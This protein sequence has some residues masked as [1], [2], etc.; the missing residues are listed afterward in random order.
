MLANKAEY[1]IIVVGAGP[2]G[3]AAA[4]LTAELGAKTLIIEEHPSIG[5]PVQCGEVFHRY[6]LDKLELDNEGIVV[7]EP[8][9]VRIYSPNR[10][11]AEITVAESASSPLVMIERKNLE[12]RLAIQVANK[13][14]K[15]IT[16]ARAVRILKE[17]NFVVGVVVN[18]LGAEYEFASKIVIAC[19]GPNSSMARSAGIDVYR[20]IENFD[21]CVQF[22]LANIE[23]DE[24]IAEIYLGA[25]APGGYTWILP[26]GKKFAN[27]GLGVSSKFGNRA[28]KYLNEFIE[29]DKRLRNGS[30]IEVNAGIVPLGGASEKLVDNGLMIVGDAARQVNPLT[31]GGMVFAI[32]AALAAGTVAVEAIANKD[33]SQ[34]F[35][36]KY[37]KIWNNDI[38]R[39][40]PAFKKLQELVLKLS[41]EELDELIGG[42]G[43]L[44]I[45]GEEEPWYPALKQ[46]FKLL[47]LN[48]KLMVKFSSIIPYFFIK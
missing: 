23:I 11:L 15:I 25:C 1:D 39:W 48:P 18:H 45:A 24:R 30:I 43:K 37:E 4:K 17:N 47:L 29:N 42:I 36:L 22:Q 32:K 35:L 33:Y 5:T 34:N 8:R 6:L 28:L 40:F 20:A 9:G 3:L 44:E 46:I 41:Y 31:G 13:G 2:A 21:S 14:A 16:K 19:D 12:K 10:K 26:K 27:V 7:N 38:G